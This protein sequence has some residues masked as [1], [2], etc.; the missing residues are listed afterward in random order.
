MLNEIPL[1]KMWK[2]VGELVSI[3]VLCWA[4]VKTGICAGVRMELKTI[5]AQTLRVCINVTQRSFQ[6]SIDMF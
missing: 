1:P 6:Y 2:S 5:A 3:G 4:I